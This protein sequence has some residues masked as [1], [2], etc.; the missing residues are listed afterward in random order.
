VE[1]DIDEE[2]EIALSH[3]SMAHLRI[4]NMQYDEIRRYTTVS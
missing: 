3:A 1:K 4:G 2:M